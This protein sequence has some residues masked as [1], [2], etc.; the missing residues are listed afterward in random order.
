MISSIV[1]NRRTLLAAGAATLA[2][3]A[4]PEST[5]RANADPS[6]A[7]IV[8]T[9]G[10]TDDKNHQELYFGPFSTATGVT[11]QLDPVAYDQ[12]AKLQAQVKSGNIQYSLMQPA[13]ADV[14][15]LGEKGLL[16]PFPQDLIDKANSVLGEGRLIGK[17]G[18]THGASASAFVCRED[19][20]TCPTNAKEFFDVQAF[21]GRRALYADGWLENIIYALQADGVA[22]E[23]LFPID[24]DRAFKKL[25]EIKPHINV[26]WKTGD[27][28]AQ[29]IRDKEVD[30]AV[31]WDGRA[32]TLP[33]DGT[34]I[35]LSVDGAFMDSASFA[36][37]AGAPNKEAA[38]AFISWWMDQAQAQGEYMNR[39]FYG[40]PNP[41][42]FEFT[43]PGLIEK[44]S[45]SAG[46][47][48]KLVQ[49]D[50]KWV[51]EHQADA[52]A[53]WTDWIQG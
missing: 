41:K 22:N 51:E 8:A 32:N 23:D 5:E 6:G 47:F 11:F 4:G 20:A 30:M 48:E 18:V 46:N 2:L 27:Q 36:V 21:P 1:L 26:F 50:L 44:V 31:V 10:G 19:F 14:A 7:I 25:D 12:V 15:N 37:P 28:A 3:L 24:L 43:Q 9:Y 33:R 45:T 35:K 40:E 42:A 29:I 39:A 34:P 49:P 16:E 38:F 52:V 53:R 17:Y 13:R